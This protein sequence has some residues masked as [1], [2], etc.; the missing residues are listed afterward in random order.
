MSLFLALFSLISTVGPTW[1][2]PEE[3]PAVR[4]IDCDTDDWDA[5]EAAL[6]RSERCAAREAEEGSLQS[7]AWGG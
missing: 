6:E 2:W 3:R 5:E 7:F 1:T 4:V